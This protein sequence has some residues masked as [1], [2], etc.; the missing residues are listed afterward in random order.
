MRLL[1]THSVCI[2]VTRLAACWREYFNLVWSKIHYGHM[3]T[4][5]RFNKPDLLVRGVQARSKDFLFR[6]DGRGEV[7]L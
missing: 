4:E 7:F 6:L 1:L 3:P 5:N 2:S